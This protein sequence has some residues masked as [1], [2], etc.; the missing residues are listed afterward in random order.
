M[1]TPT[2]KLIR[3]SEPKNFVIRSQAGSFLTSHTVCM[4]AT[5]IDRPIVRGTKMK[6]YTVVMPNCQRD[7]S[8]AFTGVLFAASLRLP[9][10]RPIKGQQTTGGAPGRRASGPVITGTLVTCAGRPRAWPALRPKV[11][12]LGA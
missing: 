5:T 9:V 8:S 12:P 7:R 6:W 3:N 1:T 4:T 11:P 10:R 2:A